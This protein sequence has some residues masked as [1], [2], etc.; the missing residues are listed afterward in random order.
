MSIPQAMALPKADQYRVTV[1]SP[2]DLQ[3][4]SLIKLMLTE[5]VSPAAFTNR[6]EKPLTTSD[7]QGLSGK[8]SKNKISPLNHLLCRMM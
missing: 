4:A 1:L 7:A 5:P 6:H 2:K 8:E 3:A